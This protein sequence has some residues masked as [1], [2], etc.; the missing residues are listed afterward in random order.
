MA[1]WSDRVDD[2]LY[3]GETVEESVDV[4]SATVVVTS[5][6]VLVFTP[7]SDGANFHQVDRPNVT[8][9]SVRAEGDRS[10]LTQGGRALLYGVVLFAAGM[11]LPLD[12]VL[13]GVALPSTTGQLGIG[14]ILGLFQTMLDLIR[15]ID[16]VMR[17]F[18]LLL[19]AFSVVPLGV[20]VWSRERT[21]EIGVA[22]EDDPIRI[23]TPD[24][25]TARVVEALEDAI[26]PPGVESETPDG[27]LDRL[28]S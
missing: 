2:L 7:D 13:G 16:D 17:A 6:R 28:L 3:D 19:V 25:E 1:R 21:L 15:S 12:A 4:G 27:L 5:H 9:V 24:M 26:L 14:G 10:F 20:Y 18:G 11:F 8:G 23:P 22:G